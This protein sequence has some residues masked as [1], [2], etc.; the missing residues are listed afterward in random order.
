M[1]SHND[2][3]LLETLWADWSPEFDSTADLA[4]V[5][6][7]LDSP[8]RIAAAVSYYRA[9]FDP[10]LHDPALSSSQAGLSGP[11]TTPTLYL[12]GANDGCMGF[13]DLGDPAVFLPPGSEVRLIERAG[14]FLH[15]EQPQVVN[16]A[17]LEFLGS[18][19]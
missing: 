4:A 5:R 9:M 6:R 10:S 19:D 1:V 16:N 8:E 12:H 15:L 18:A 3:Q 11:L 13:D 14:H 2:Y 17:I 7:A